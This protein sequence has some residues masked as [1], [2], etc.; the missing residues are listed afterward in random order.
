MRE[1]GNW[2]SK[3]L[4][5]WRWRSEWIP[6]KHCCPF[7]EVFVDDVLLPFVPRLEEGVTKPALP[8]PI[9][10]VFVDMGGF[11]VLFPLFRILALL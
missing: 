2:R 5:H 9:T 3:T 11:L 1:A 4:H 6:G 10:L 8:E 7:A